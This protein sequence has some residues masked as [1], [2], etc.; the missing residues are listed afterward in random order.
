MN[1]MSPFAARPR[2]WTRR[3]V[4]GFFAASSLAVEH[5]KGTLLGSEFERFSDPATELPVARLSNPEYS[6]HLPAY[7]NRALSRKGQFLICW[8]DRT[9]SPQAF[10]INLKTGE[11]LQLTD[12]TALDGSSLTLM[13]DER[14]FCFFDG[15]ALKRVDFGKFREH[16]IYRVPDDWR[17]CPGANLTDDGL[18]A[19]FAECR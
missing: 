13:P 7:Y 1:F 19:I 8:S 15:A 18:Y 4:L 10:R 6:T 5:G 16:E 11:W 2:R 3:S 12:A 9:G 14:S 17:R